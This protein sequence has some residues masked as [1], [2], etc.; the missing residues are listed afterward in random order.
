MIMLNLIDDVFFFDLFCV[1]IK[2]CVEGLLMKL[3]F[4]IIGLLYVMIID[5]VVCE[6]LKDIE[7]FCCDLIL[8]IG[9]FLV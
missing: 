9:K 1:L 5:V 2:V 7:L 8:I 4:L 3:W 6:V